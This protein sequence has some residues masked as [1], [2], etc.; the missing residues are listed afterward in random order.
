[1]CGI[2]GITGK[3]VK[4]LGPSRIDAMLDSLSHRGPDDRGVLAFP[5]SAKASEGAASCVLGQTRLSIIDLSGGH[6][7]MK[8]NQKNIAITFNGE[9]YN[10]R[11]LK[12]G[13]EQKGHVFSTK[14]DTEVILKAYIE[15]GTDCPKHLEGMFSFALWDEE[16]KT[17]FGARDRFGEKPLYYAKTR[18]GNMVFASEIKALLASGLIDPAVNKKALDIYLSLT[19][20]PPHMTIY[21]NISVVPP[22]SRFMLKNNEVVMEKYWELAKKELAIAYAD[23]KIEARRLLERAVSKMMVADVEVGAL[24]SGGVDSTLV[25]YFAQQTSHFPI[26]TFSVGYEHYINELPFAEQVAKKFGTDHHTLQA[27]GDMVERL[28][29]V[30]KSLDEPHADPSNFPQYLVSQFASS[31]VKVALTGDGADELFMGYGWYWKHHNLSWKADFLEKAFPNPF[32][33]FLKS[34]A[35]FTPAEKSI[36]LREPARNSMFVP[37]NILHARI[38][39]IE[40]INLFDLSFYLPGKLLSK[41]DRTAMMN[42]LETRCPFLDRELTE[43]IYNLPQDFKIDNRNGK[44]ILKDILSDIMPKEFVYRRKQGF[45]APVKEWLEVTEMKALV[46]DTLDHND[47]LYAYL[48]KEEVQKVLNA[49][50]DKTDKTAYYKIWTLLCLGLWFQTHPSISSG[51]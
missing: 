18:S 30:C 23:A 44:L 33:N 32:K 40:K 6:Q 51:L 31:K 49:F 22:A 13:L 24:L 25:T 15:Y 43:F 27:K 35:V 14:S 39:D 9:I 16:K 11:E 3:N 41:V 2:I 17:L 34:T 48:N 12:A 36:L 21:E 26:K 47:T 8:D 50:Y 28:R 42:S 45:G 19:Y 20:I 10:Y 38:D 29:E 4:E 37:Q 1:M 5:S 46:Y 7:P